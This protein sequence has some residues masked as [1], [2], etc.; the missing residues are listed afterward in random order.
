MDG[1]RAVTM[2]WPVFCRVAIPAALLGWAGPLLA[3]DELTT[4]L[5]GGP[6]VRVEPSE[7]GKFKRA[8][9]VADVDAPLSLVWDVINTQEKYPEFM[10]RLKKL[11]VKVESPTVKV[12]SYVLDTPFADT[13][14][15][16][17]W[18]INPEQH[19]IAATH[20][21]GDLR[22]SDYDWKVV[23][24]SPE[25]TRIYYG[26]VTRNFSTMA[27]RLEDDQQTITVGVNVVGLVAA[28]KA[29]KVR[30]EGKWRTQKAVGAQAPVEVVP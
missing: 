16:L 27:Q 6:M 5:Q 14:Y 28:V 8:L 10:P 3:A 1:G 9:C 13:A 19:T 15:S 23:A 26:G 20:V 11:S 30:A 17:R 4:L 24:M 18:T 12:V 22:G 29:I 2:R 7:N 21:S 25:V